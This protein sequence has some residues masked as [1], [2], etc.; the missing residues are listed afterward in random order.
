MISSLKIPLFTIR[1]QEIGGTEFAIYNL[2]RGLAQTNTRVQIVYDTLKH[3]SPE[4]CDWLSR[5]AID[6]SSAFPLPGPKNIRFLQETL[7]EWSR[8]GCDWALYP[9]YFIPPRR[10]LFR[11]RSAVILHDIQYKVLPQ[12]HTRMRKAWLDL[13]L[14][15]M[16]ERADRVIV[17]SHSEKRYVEKFFGPKAAMKC[18]V[19]PNAIDWD[20]FNGHALP[21]DETEFGKLLSQDYLLTVCHQFPH[22]N[23]HTLLMAFEEIAVRHHDIRLHMVGTNS[24]SN[25]EFV[26]TKL[27]A[28][29]RE[30][31]KLLGFLSDAELGQLYRSAKLFVLPSLYEGFGM[32]AVEALGLGTPI[33]VSGTTALPEATLGLGSYVQRPTDVDEWIEKIE[34][35]LATPRPPTTNDVSKIRRTFEPRSTALALLAALNDS[36]AADRHLNPDM[37]R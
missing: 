13:Y 31:V 19:V 24:A 5:T 2:V 18:R 23:L 8:S 22:K 28:A 17:I 20:R 1:H 15:R 25:Q 7:F 14:P 4:F 12:Y 32:P 34:R 35:A 29:A 11:G 10:P 6:Q 33:L 16:F 21:D 27:S 36:S 26:A 9:N 3:L 37:K 30:R